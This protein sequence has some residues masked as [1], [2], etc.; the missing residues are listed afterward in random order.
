MIETTFT[1]T[2]AN[3]ME[4]HKVLYAKTAKRFRL[5]ALAGMA[6]LIAGF[7]LLAV[8]SGDE[9]NGSLL[10]IFLGAFW[11]IFCLVNANSAARKATKRTLQANKRLSE[12]DVVTRIRFYN[13]TLKA[14]NEAT[15]KE[16]TV[17]MADVARLLR[18]E[19]LIALILSDKTCLLADRRS[20]DEETGT[21]LWERLCEQCTAAIIEEA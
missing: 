12:T 19:H 21:A 20:V 14:K 3:L 9:P 4:L 6:L 1:Y 5:L 17:A 13:N 8:Q 15:E 16:M 7:Y 10:V 11:M 2:K 18:T